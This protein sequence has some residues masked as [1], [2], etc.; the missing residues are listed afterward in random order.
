MATDWGQWHF[1]EGTAVQYTLEPV[2]NIEQ[3]LKY[4]LFFNQQEGK[5]DEKELPK[6]YQSRT[7]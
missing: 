4:Y 3:L 2:Q 7:I 6:R 5:E 1:A